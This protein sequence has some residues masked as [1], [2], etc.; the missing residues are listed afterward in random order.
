MNMQEPLIAMFVILGI[1]LVMNV[2]SFA[3]N[4]FLV[5]TP[6]FI[7][8]K[9]MISELK[10]EYDELKKA[11]DKL[12]PKQLKKME[13]KLRSIQKMELE[14]GFK[15]FKPYIFTIAI[16]WVIYWWLEKVYANLGSFVYS[17]IP[18]PIIGVSMNFFWWYVICSSAIG[19]VIMKFLYP[20]F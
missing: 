5:Y 15:S 19:F 14:L 20:K 12:E 11:A 4:K 8:K 3:I 1:S 10:K 7:K 6:E 2:V 18:L 16:F 13:Q 17:P 9:K